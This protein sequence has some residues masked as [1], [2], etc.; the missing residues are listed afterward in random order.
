MAELYR[1]AHQCI[2]YYPEHSMIKRVLSGIA[3]NANWPAFQ[4]ECLEYASIVRVYKPQY[5]L[6]DARKFQIIML[7][8]MQDWVNDNLINVFNEIMLQ[9]CAIIIPPQFLHQLGIE[10]TIE[11]NPDNAFEVQYFENEEDAIEWLKSGKK[12]QVYK[13]EL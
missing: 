4:V 2:E 12:Y 8:E 1:S 13:L 10:Q 11:A 5:I 9:K 6:S 3:E 7:K